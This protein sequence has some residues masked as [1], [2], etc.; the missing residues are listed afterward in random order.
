MQAIRHHH[1]KAVKTA[2][3][4]VAGIW[5]LGG[6]LTIGFLWYAN[7]SHPRLLNPDDLAPAFT[8]SDQ[9]GRPHKLQDYRGRAVA[10]AF[11][12][13]LAE[14]SILELRSLNKEIRKFDTLGVNLFAIAPANVEAAREIHNRESLNFPILI[15]SR[16][17][18]AWKYGADAHGEM[19]K[20]SSFVVGTDGRVLLPI[21][22]VHTAIHGEQLVELAECCVDQKPEAPSRF[23]GKPIDDFELANVST[24]KP[25]SLYGDRSQRLT[26]LFVLS[27]QCPC[28]GKYDARVTELAKQYRPKGVRFIAVNSSANETPH[29]IVAYAKQAGYPFPVLKDRGNVIAD[30]IE[31]QVTPEAFVMDDKGM[32]RYHGRIDD[33]RDPSRV[34][35]HDLR[36]ALDFLLA[37]KNPVAND[38]ATFGCAIFRQDKPKADV[39]LRMSE[40]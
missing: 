16:Q 40:Q 10:L 24:G 5:L 39:P 30:H 37:S 21:S 9:D 2:F 19:G 8:L 22:A 26:V 18:V 25:E 27:A 15:D 3:L 20:R 36:N 6:L 1:M 28:S 7:N 38:V 34:Q 23:I 17:Q 32:L 12:P 29:E 13:D 4:A 31:A 14:T 35:K 11:M 33:N